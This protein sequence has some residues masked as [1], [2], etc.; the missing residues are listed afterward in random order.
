MEKN[1]YVKVVIWITILTLLS[2]FIGFLREVLFANYYG[3]TIES[4]AF[5][6]ALTVAG[7]VTSVLF[8]SLK[9]S[10]I[11]VYSELAFG[12]DTNKTKRFVDSSYTVILS[13]ILFFSIIAFIFSANWGLSYILTS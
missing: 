3:A 10:Y 7:I 4:D 13:L 12:N 5:L 8:I 11:P 9:N 1:K 6:L 2:R